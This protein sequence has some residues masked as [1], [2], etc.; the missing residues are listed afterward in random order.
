MEQFETFYKQYYKW[1]IYIAE[2]IIQNEGEAE[3]IAQSCFIKLYQR[4][5]VCGDMDNKK[6]YMITLIKHACIGYTKKKTVREKYVDRLDLSEIDETVDNASIAYD[7]LLLKI[8]ESLPKQCKKIFIL[9]ALGKKTREIA[10]KLK[11]DPRTV[12]NQKTRAI[13]LLRPIALK[14]ISSH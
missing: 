10:Q 2:H 5:K 4:M 8:S 14:Y 6:A 3:D 12:L 1:A 13:T 9:Y 7:I 11:I